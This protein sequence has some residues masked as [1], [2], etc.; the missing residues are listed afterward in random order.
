M[1]LPTWLLIVW[2]LVVLGILAAY[3]FVFHC[4]YGWDVEQ[5]R[6]ACKAEGE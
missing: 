3:P 5:M 2:T 4:S 6:I 1:K